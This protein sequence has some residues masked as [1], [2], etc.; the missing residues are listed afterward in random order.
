MSESLRSLGT[1]ILG[2]LGAIFIACI[3]IG[4]ETAGAN[5]RAWGEVLKPSAPSATL[6]RIALFFLVVSWVGIVIA[7]VQRQR[8]RQFEAVRDEI[9][10]ILLRDYAGK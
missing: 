2:I 7:L 1:T 9:E 4:P 8:E 6:E 5:L 3:S 10:K